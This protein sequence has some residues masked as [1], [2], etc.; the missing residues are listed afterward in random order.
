MSLS[1]KSMVKFIGPSHRGAGYLLAGA[2]CVSRGQ[3]ATWDPEYLVRPAWSWESW[4]SWASVWSHSAQR[5]SDE[6][7]PPGGLAQYLPL[8]EVWRHNSIA[9]WVLAMCFMPPD[10]LEKASRKLQ[11][12]MPCMPG[13]TCLVTISWFFFLDQI[14]VGLAETGPPMPDAIFGH[15]SEALFENNF[16]SLEKNSLFLLVWDLVWNDKWLFCLPYPALLSS[17]KLFCEKFPGWLEK[18]PKDSDLCICTAITP[19]GH[20]S[21]AIGTAGNIF[22]LICVCAYWGRCGIKL[23]IPRAFP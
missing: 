8:K 10:N 16:I 5:G 14:H 13:K 1:L 15:A 4:G 9:W 21:W 18:P 11:C 3:V 17:Q 22:P 20:D 12:T 23:R 7:I 2:D 6:D 19:A